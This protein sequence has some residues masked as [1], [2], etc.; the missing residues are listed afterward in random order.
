MINREIQLDMLQRVAEALGPDLRKKMTFVGGCTTG[1]LVTDEFTREQIRHTDDV[2]LIMHVMSYT[3][4][5]ALQQELQAHGFKIEVPDDDGAPICAMKLGD[6]RVD[7]MPDDENILGFTN[8]WY[9]KA[10]E[11]S[12]Y[13]N[14]APELSINL[15]S[16]VYFI[17]TKLEAY[18]GRGKGDPLESRDIEDILNLVDGRPELVNEIST[19]EN[20]L[21]IYISQQIEVLIKLSDFD[22]VIQSHTY[23]DKAREDEIY[24]RLEKIIEIGK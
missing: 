8:R 16:P 22:Y 19:A 1:L 4:Y 23:G 24:E 13:F 15:I 10:M 5:S 6:L 7:F 21:K 17:A 20:D 12:T 9:R 18:N 11:T 3:S 2:D 14:L